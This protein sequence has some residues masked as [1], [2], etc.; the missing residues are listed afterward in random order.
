VRHG[1][2]GGRETPERAARHATP[3]WRGADPVRGPT[4]T[5]PLGRGSGGKGGVA[6]VAGTWPGGRAGTPSPGVVAGRA[7]TPRHAKRG[8]FGGRESYNWKRRGPSAVDSTP[9]GAVP[10]YPDPGQQGNY[11]SRSR[12]DR[13]RSKARHFPS[14]FPNPPTTFLNFSLWRDLSVWRIWGGYFGH[15]RSGLIGVFG[16]W[17]RRPRRRLIKPTVLWTTILPWAL[18]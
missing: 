6:V 17:G 2:C 10:K 18:P 4:S 16:G 15:R 12:G 11:L 5:T 13:I 9:P 3:V 7:G 1:G 8:L 14:G